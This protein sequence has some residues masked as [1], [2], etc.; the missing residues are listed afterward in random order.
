MYETPVGPWKVPPSKVTPEVNL[1]KIWVTPLTAIS[2]TPYGLP[3]VPVSPV[4]EEPV[5]PVEPVDPVGPVAAGNPV[6]P[7]GPIGPVKPWSPNGN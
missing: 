2:V 5:G 3:L 4:I 6:S 1:V 7:V